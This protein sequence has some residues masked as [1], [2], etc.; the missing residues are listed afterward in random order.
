MSRIWL[1]A[2]VLTGLLSLF[3]CDGMNKDR[4]IVKTNAIYKNVKVIL[5]DPVVGERLSE[6]RKEQLRIVERVYLEA[7][8]RLEGLESLDG[9][10]GKEILGEIVECCEILLDVIDGLEVGEEY[11]EVVEVV[12][13]RV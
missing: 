6:E 12:R 2:M 4:V 13:L 11:E 5:T 9:V 7:A 8:E 10:E 3:G 1:A